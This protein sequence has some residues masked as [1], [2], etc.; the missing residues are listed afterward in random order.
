MS[1]PNKQASE[2]LGTEVREAFEATLS[3]KP[4]EFEALIARLCACG[5]RRVKSARR[6][7]TARECGQRI[8]AQWCRVGDRGCLLGDRG[9]NTIRLVDTKFG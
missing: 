1:K 8:R 5:I 9:K 7:R 3:L 4:A 2:E 6:T